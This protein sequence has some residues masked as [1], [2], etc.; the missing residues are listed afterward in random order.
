MPTF[1]IALVALYVFFFR[2]E[3]VPGRRA[4]RPGRRSTRRTSPA[5]TR[6]TRCFAGQWASLGKALHHLVLPA[7]V[8]AAFNVSLLDALHALGGARGDR[9]RLRARGAREGHARADRRRALHP[10]RR[11]AVGHHGARPRLR[12][13]A[14]RRGAR[15]EDLLLA[16]ASASTRTRPRSTSTCPAIAGVS[17]FVAVVYVDGQLHRRRPL[18]RHRPADPGDVSEAR[19]RSARPPPRSAP[20]DPARPGASRSRSPA[21]AIAVAW[22]IIAIFAPLIA[23]HDPLAQNVRRARSR[24][25]SDHLVRHRRARPRRPQPRH[26]R[27]AGVAAARARCSSSLASTIG[28][29]ARRDRRLLPRRRSTASC[30]RLTD[31]VFAFPAIILAMVVA[32]VARPRPARTPCSRIVIVAWPSYA[33]IV[34][35]LVLSVGDS[36]YV[37]SARLL[38]VERAR[39]LVRDVLPN[40]AGPVLVLDD[41]RPRQR[42]SC[43]SPACRS[44][45]SARSRRSRS[46]ASM[47]ADGH[48]VLP[49]VVDRH[50]PG[51]RDLHGRARLQLP[52]RQPARRL[53]PA[54]RGSGGGR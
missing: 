1:W 2:L 37:Q 27:R 9:Q 15:R 24:R 50:V 41:A 53:R 52:R 12:E 14:H 16:R 10:A 6:S 34:R 47:V 30:M 19:R 21:L 45:A 49:V 4:A 20:A 5:S 44:S 8:L 48:A 13:R 29:D 11:A 18:R 26:L 46:G 22:L 36:E 54:S 25:R 51:P 33:R 40:V 39:T 38:G 7:L 28:G 35:G 43:C 3:L 31:L 23:P 17:L 32:A 42:R